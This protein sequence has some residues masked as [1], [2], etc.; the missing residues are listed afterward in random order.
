MASQMGA[1]TRVI[2]IWLGICIT[3]YLQSAPSLLAS[4]PSSS[5]AEQLPLPCRG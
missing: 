5:Y 2:I 1:P 4:A 3:Q